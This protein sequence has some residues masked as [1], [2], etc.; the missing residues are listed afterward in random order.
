MF[1]KEGGMDERK[2]RD[3]MPGEGEP[4]FLVAGRKVWVFQRIVNGSR[5]GERV[6]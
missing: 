4:L 1:E 6:V 3:E 2:G 5:F